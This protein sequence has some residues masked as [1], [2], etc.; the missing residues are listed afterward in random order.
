MATP[1]RRSRLSVGVIGAGTVGT[2]LAVCLQ[3][4]GYPV[5][6]AASRSFV[7]AQRLAEQVPGCAAVAAPQA[8]AD[9]ADVVFLTV[10]DDAIQEVADG[11]E[12]RALQMVLHCS[13][14]QP[15]AVLR[16]PRR[17]A[18]MVGALHPLQT[19]SN[20]EAALENLPGS[21]F[22]VEA[23]EPLLGILQGMAHALGGRAVGLAT[24]DRILY[25]ISGVLASNY[26]VTLL[27]LAADIWEEFGFGRQEALQALLPLVRGTVRNIEASGIPGSLTGPIAR[28]DAGTIES[29][30]RELEEKRPDLLNLYR[31]L[32]LGTV[33]IGEEKGRLDAEGATRMRE[34]LQKQLVREGRL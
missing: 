12:W 3:E 13:G 2:A 24:E 10:P 19:F 26:L 21:T 18:A 7:S 32:G 23:D 1:R 6:A 33:S 8:V 11:L 4:A 34:L 22:A 20:V 16:S 14:T 28:G 15:L 17:L 27:A 29:H 25:H 30:L 9:R 31:S 5:V